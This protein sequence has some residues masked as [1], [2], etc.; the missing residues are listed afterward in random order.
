MGGVISK[1]D[2]VQI[3]PLHTKENWNMES[4]KAGGMEDYPCVSPFSSMVI[5]TDGI[6]PLCCLDSD[7]KIIIGNLSVDSIKDVWNSDLMH[8]IRMKHLR[9]GRGEVSICKNCNCWDRTFKTYHH[10]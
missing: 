4:S 1:I 2:K 7:R 8:D 5:D 10:E 3:M 9:K 6:V